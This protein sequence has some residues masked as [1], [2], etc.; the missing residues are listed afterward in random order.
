MKKFI[1]P[2]IALATAFTA[3]QQ[4][5]R[6]KDVSDT[7]AVEQNIV[8]VSDTFC[9][10]YIKN[11]DTA[12]LNFTTTNGITTGELSYKLYEK[13]SNKG[14]IEGEMKGDTLL[15]DYTFNSEGSESV[16]QV[17][18][19]KKGDQLIEGFGD[20][21]EKNGKTVFKKTANLTFGNSIVFE[22]GDCK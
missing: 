16:R 14:I 18:F 19:L 22:K 6:T 12:M 13:D 2:T 7:V 8:K 11:R 17:A 1:V 9:Y 3:C 4:P 21:E 5:N 15:A 20:V 10:A